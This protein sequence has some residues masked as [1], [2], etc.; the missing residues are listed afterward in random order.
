MAAIFSKDLLDLPEQ[1]RTEQS[2]RHGMLLV[3]LSVSA[4]IKAIRLI[5]GCYRSVNDCLDRERRLA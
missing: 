4:K 5:T 1:N 3:M 2:W